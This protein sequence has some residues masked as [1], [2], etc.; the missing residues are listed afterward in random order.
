MEWF[1]VRPLSE[2]DLDAVIS[3][4]GGERA[5]RDADR[6]GQPGADYRLAEAVIELKA[7]DDEGLAKPERQAKLAALFRTHSQGRPVIVLDREALPLRAQVEYDR[8]ME[9]PIKTAIAKARKQLKQSRK[10]FADVACSIFMIINNGYTALDHKS[11][12]RLAANRVRNDTNEIDGLVV[13]GCYYYSDGFD[14]YMVCP[15]DYIPINFGRSFV[16]FDK[17]K[18]AWNAYVDEFMTAVVL[19]KL[20]AA[21]VKGPVIDTQ[22]DLDGVTYVKPAPPIGESSGFF[23]PTRPRKN[24]SGLDRCPPVATTYPA[25]TRREWNLFRRALPDEPD[26]FQTFNE[27]QVRLVAAAAC[28]TALQP[29]VPV[30]VNFQ[31][32]DEWCRKQRLLRSLDAIRKYANAVFE[33][34]VRALAAAAREHQSISI[35]PHRYVLAVTEEIGQDKANDVS[36]IAVIRER[37]DGSSAIRPLVKNIRIFHEHAVILASAYALAEGIEFVLWKKDLTYAWV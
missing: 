21:S 11:L 13:A 33:R 18:M 23:G 5:Y 1:R 15:F 8:T 25:M 30:S 2:T 29:F 9:G 37:S 27:W 3:N 24:T 14:R 19:G 35:L 7:L 4:A 28:G 16:S 34:N 12:T 6:R 22:F 32:W 31:D 26:L 17:L 10:E 36:N 20:E